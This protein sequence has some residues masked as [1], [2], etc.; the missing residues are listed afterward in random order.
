MS[1]GL[2]TIRAYALQPTFQTQ[3]DKLVDDNLKS[4]FMFYAIQRWLA[5]R[6]DLVCSIITFATAIFG[7]DDVIID[8]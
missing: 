2:Q 7:G 3:F 6:L 8:F 5:Y 1:E 4:Y